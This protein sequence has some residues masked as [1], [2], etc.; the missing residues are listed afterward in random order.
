MHWAQNMTRS[1]TKIFNIEN[2]EH[3]DL[4]ERTLKH[5]ESIED[6]EQPESGVLAKRR[7]MILKSSGTVQPPRHPA[8]W[9]TMS[10]PAVGIQKLL[11]VLLLALWSA[12]DVDM[13]PLTTFCSPVCELKKLNG[14]RRQTHV[15]P[16]L[17]S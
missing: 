6:V 15:N 2:I 9:V 8:A 11:L 16:K 4:I 7:Q 17:L 12:S 13:P 14:T 1:N 3:I 10:D 5:I